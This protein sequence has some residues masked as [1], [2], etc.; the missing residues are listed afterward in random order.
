MEWAAGTSWA[1]WMRSFLPSSSRDEPVRQAI[2]QRYG[3]SDVTLNR[4]AWLGLFDAESG[5]TV[6]KGTPAQVL[7]SLLE[8]KWELQPND[9][10]M[11]VM[12]HRFAY[13]L[14]GQMHEV[15]SSLRLE[16]RDAVYTG[17]SDTVGWPVALAAEA[18][19]AGKFKG[20]GVQVP[21]HKD[22]YEVILPALEKLG[23]RF[24]ETHRICS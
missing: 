4:L 6:L 22:Y 1:D 7:Q 13:R 14:N 18:L 9:R 8:V 3:T 12:W 21:L 16:G 10:D 19:L 17:M 2:A 24:E 15:T 23:V 20:R 5:P 11:I